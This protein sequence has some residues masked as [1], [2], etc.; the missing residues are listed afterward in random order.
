MPKERLAIEVSQRLQRRR[1]CNALLYVPEAG[2]PAFHRTRRYEFGFTGSREAVKR[3]ARQV[4]LDPVSQEL[5]CGE[6]AVY[7]GYSFILDYGMKPGVLDLEKEAVLQFHKKSRDGLCAIEAL[8]ITK[9]LYI[10]RENGEEPSAASLVRDIVNPA[11]HTWTVTHA[12]R[13]A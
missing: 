3:F 5:H 11:I 13:D 1:S 6:E 4:L 9:R 7:A 2:A 10:F 12:D 8:R